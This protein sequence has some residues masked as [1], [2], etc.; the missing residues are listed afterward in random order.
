ME[1]KI[2]RKLNRKTFA[3]LCHQFLLQ[4]SHHFRYNKRPLSNHFCCGHFFSQ[5]T[6][7]LSLHLFVTFMLFSFISD[8]IGMNLFFF[9]SQI[10]QKRHEETFFCSTTFTKIY[11]TMFFLLLFKTV[12]EYFGNT[13]DTCSLF[14]CVC[15]SYPSSVWWCNHKARISKHRRLKAPVA[16]SITEET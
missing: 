4:V 11:C 13:R 12:Q 16:R 10:K 15:C 9:M 8:A 14:G 3:S 7:N 5:R 1:S 6:I 2:R